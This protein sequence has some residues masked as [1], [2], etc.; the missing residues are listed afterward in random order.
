MLCVGFSL[1]WCVIFI[2]FDVGVVG[3]DTRTPCHDTNLSGTH[4]YRLNT[5]SGIRSCWKFNVSPAVAK[6]ESLY[7]F[8]NVP[9]YNT[10][11][12]VSGSISQTHI[13]DICLDSSVACLVGHI[14]GS[15][16]HVADEMWFDI[17]HWDMQ[18][19]FNLI[20]YRLLWNCSADSSEWFPDT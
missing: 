2:H 15:S 20:L 6:Q 1:T 3:L 13:H 14:L 7:H 17:V 5:T 9:P 19:I 10:R 12:I 8:I 16:G 18:T 11:Y 4:I